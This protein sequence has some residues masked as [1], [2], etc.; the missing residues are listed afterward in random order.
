MDDDGYQY[1]RIKE[2]NPCIPIPKMIGNDYPHKHFKSR[3][4][5]ATVPI[6]CSLILQTQTTR[7]SK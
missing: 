3:I 2:I 6:Y 7:L 4:E 5:V 1:R